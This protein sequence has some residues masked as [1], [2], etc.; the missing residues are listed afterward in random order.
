MKIHIVQKG[1]TLWKISKKYGVDFEQL[2][3]MNQQLANPDMIMP[4]MKI[5][6]PSSGNMNV[7]KNEQQKK[8][9]PVKKEMPVKEKP[10]PKQPEVKKPVAPPPPPMA[11]A[12]PVPPPQPQP[13]YL[14]QKAKV[15]LNFYHQPSYPKMP[16]PEPPKKPV[17]EVKL[18]EKPKTMPKPKPKPKPHKIVKPMP[19]D[20][21]PEKKMPAPKPIKTM[22]P[23]KPKP[24]PYHAPPAYQQVGP[25][26]E[27]CIPL[28]A[29]CGYGCHPMVYPNAM[30]FPQPQ[31]QQMYQGNHQQ[32]YH[33][34]QPANA[35]YH[36][37]FGQ[38]H[39][40]YQQQTWSRYE[41]T[42]V[43]SLENEEQQI[44]T[45]SNEEVYGDVTINNGLSNSG[46]ATEK[47]QNDELIPWTYP[48][49]DHEE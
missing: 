15:D 47:R 9:Y 23:A 49:K 44:N 8:E 14:K 42:A 37:Q 48:T 40:P 28:S 16:A 7:K 12:P 20:K 2:K 5:N 24:M 1:D 29:L 4:G 41:E 27:G 25:L 11:P 13:S 10:I 21:I 32:Y 3:T 18:K 34:H 33:Q 36:G 45:R 31:M 38:P 6:I 35:M 22:P 17:K 26:I 39:Q 30:V 43:Q 19:V 46:Y